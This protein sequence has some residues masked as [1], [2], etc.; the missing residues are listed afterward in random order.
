VARSHFATALIT[1]LRFLDRS[2]R[3]KYGST[4]FWY[5][6]IM[7]GRSLVLSPGHASHEANPQER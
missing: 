1:H 4:C 6:R 3:I 2:G 7:Q 5:R